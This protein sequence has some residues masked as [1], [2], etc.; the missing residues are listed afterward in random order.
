[1]K[2][3]LILLV[4]IL[5]VVTAAAVFRSFR[6]LLK[7]LGHLLWLTLQR[8]VLPALVAATGLFIVLFAESLAKSTAGAGRLLTEGMQ[9]FARSHIEPFLQPKFYEE[10]GVAFI[11]SGLIAFMVEFNFHSREQHKVERE[12]AAIARSVFNYL[13]GSLAPR[14]LTAKVT[15][16]YKMKLLR[17][18]IVIRFTFKDPPHEVQQL[19]PHRKPDLEDLLSVQMELKYSLKNLTREHIPVDI[20]HTLTPSVP[21]PPDYSGFIELEV[22]DGK[23]QQVAH[24]HKGDCN[25]VVRCPIGSDRLAWKK[26]E[27]RLRDGIFIKPKEKMNVVVRQEAVRWC[28]D[29]A[30]WITAL[31]ATK[32]TVIADNQHYPGIEFLLDEAHP[33]PFIK[34]PDSWE[35]NSAGQLI[36]FQG[37]TLH[38]FPAPKDDFSNP[39]PNAP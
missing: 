21:L 17:D 3:L 13:L 5:A 6:K 15:D 4:L 20:L 28:N 1:M 9:L 34:E 23:G 8:S 11:I 38:W 18:K 26:R 2:L 29:H 27:I 24:W 33:K 37:F 22:T 19:P 31:P 35:W 30:T 12:R 10:V 25:D 36:P 7:R 32:I 14:W 39:T 16:L